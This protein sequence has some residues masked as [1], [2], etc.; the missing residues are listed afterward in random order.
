MAEQKG[1]LAVETP[2]AEKQVVSKA[3]DEAVEYLAQR[4]GFAPLSPEEEKKMIRKM[5]WIL[6]PMVCSKPSQGTRV[7]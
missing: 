7:S 1:V 5:D 4:A 2:E 6:L 3:M